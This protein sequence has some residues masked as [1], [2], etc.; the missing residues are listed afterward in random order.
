MYQIEETFCDPCYS[1][2]SQGISQSCCW[3]RALCAWIWNANFNVNRLRNGSN[4]NLHCFRAEMPP[5]ALWPGPSK[6]GL[7]SAAPNCN[8]CIKPAKE[9]PEPSIKTH[10]YCCWLCGC[11]IVCVCVARGAR[12]SRWELQHF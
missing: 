10:C 12:L 11:A 6:W 8:D 1:S 9:M 3:L 4:C 7:G 5:E 2:T